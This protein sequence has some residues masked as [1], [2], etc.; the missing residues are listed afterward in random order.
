MTFVIKL[1]ANVI[2]KKLHC[3][4]VIKEKRRYNDGKVNHKAILG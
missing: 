2:G 3:T 4:R 1:V